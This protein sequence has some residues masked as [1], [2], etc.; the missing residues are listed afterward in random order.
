M[1]GTEM[2]RSATLR[3]P[4]VI[5]WSDSAKADGEVDICHP[6]AAYPSALNGRLATSSTTFFVVRERIVNRRQSFLVGRLHTFC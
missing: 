5:A 4:A 6:R 2:G 1:A 3:P